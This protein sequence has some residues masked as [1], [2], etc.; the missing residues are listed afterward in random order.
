MILTSGD[1]KIFPRGIP[2]ATITKVKD[3]EAFVEILD[4][5]SKINFVVVVSHAE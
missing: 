4:D 1:G 5:L 2:I 3:K